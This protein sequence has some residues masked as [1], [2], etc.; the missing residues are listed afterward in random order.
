VIDTKIRTVKKEITVKRH[1]DFSY[2]SI[3]RISDTEGVDRLISEGGEVFYNYVASLGLSNDPNMIVLSSAHHYYYDSE[4]M[5]KTKTV[6]N[7]KELNR[8][9]EISALLHSHLHFLPE[10]CNFVGCFVNNNKIER[11][12]LRRSHTPQE[13]EKTSD[14]EE[15]GIISRSPFM[16]MLFSIMDA[17]TESYMSDKTVKLM[18]ENYGFEVLDMTEVNGLTYFHSRKVREAYN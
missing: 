2:S 12:T 17:R 7:L 18:L 4:E 3:E 15:L 14:N 5:R 9:K 16:N 8:I 1:P 6:V 13:R 11:F 10:M